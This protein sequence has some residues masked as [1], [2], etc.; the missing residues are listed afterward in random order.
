M[1]RR[2]WPLYDDNYFTKLTNYVRGPCGVYKFFKKFTCP[3]TRGRITLDGKE[4]A[5]FDDGLSTNIKKIKG[6]GGLDKGEFHRGQFHNSLWTFL[7]S[8]IEQNLESEKPIIR[9]F[10]FLDKR[11]GKRRLVKIKK[12]GLHHLELFFYELRMKAEKLAIKN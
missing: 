7:H 3:L 8:S 11:L 2:W 10:G 12:E 1:T 9:A 5:N 4:I 6:R